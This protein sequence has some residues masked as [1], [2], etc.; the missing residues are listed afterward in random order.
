[1]VQLEMQHLA[2]KHSKL[3]GGADFKF[4][5]KLVSKD[6]K[7]LVGELVNGEPEAA[8]K[9]LARQEILRWVKEY[10]TD[11]L[12]SYQNGR[13]VLFS[14]KDEE[15]TYTPSSTAS[16]NE[17][18]QG[19]FNKMS[20]PAEN[21]LVPGND[22]A[23]I[24]S[25]HYEKGGVDPSCRAKDPVCLGILKLAGF[26]LF[27]QGHQPVKPT[28]V[29]SN[30]AEGTASNASLD[31]LTVP[32]NK[33]EQSYN[34]IIKIKK[35]Q[36]SGTSSMVIINEILMPKADSTS[37]QKAKKTSEQKAE[38][39]SGQK[40]DKTYT[41][42]AD[43]KDPSLMS[44]A[45]VTFD[46]SDAKPGTYHVLGCVEA[47]GDHKGDFI[48]Q[49]YTEFKLPNGAIVSN[50]TVENRRFITEHDY[51][52]LHE[53]GK[54][55]H[56]RPEQKTYLAERLINKA[57]TEVLTNVEKELSLPT[58]LSAEI[59]QT[60]QAFNKDF[61]TLQ[62]T[63]KDTTGY[64]DKVQAC[65]KK[66]ENLFQH[67]LSIPQR[68]GFLHAFVQFWRKLVNLFLR[69]FNTQL[70]HQPL[71]SFNKNAPAVQLLTSHKILGS[72]DVNQL[73]K[74]MT[75]DDYVIK[76]LSDLKTASAEKETSNPTW[77]TDEKGINRM[78]S[79]GKKR[80]SLFYSEGADTKRSRVN[81][82]ITTEQAKKDADE[83]T[84]PASS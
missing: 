48:L 11:F 29:F 37:E 68:S 54:V 31:T 36:K 3:G 79:I 78:L 44:G 82:D 32:P 80:G 64:Q 2:I 61:K 30:N 6:G 66:L 21:P 55:S 27:T 65:V 19:H 28:P 73:E 56:L 9:A 41:I 74:L 13:K 39:T 52:K 12:N 23:F 67:A 46:K 58:T 33:G 24:S 47:A 5:E 72:A 20:L 51:L 1:M 81:P 35:P 4:S 49:H 17:V 15:I 53:A 59:T 50:A 60:T 18:G 75:S 70:G 10:N 34:V 7:I 38:K 26:D 62:S 16:N 14:E 22:H 77:R 57:L 76:F 71:L 69:I 83:T 43:F 45:R 63:E 40:A 8:V 25:S 84:T 42:K